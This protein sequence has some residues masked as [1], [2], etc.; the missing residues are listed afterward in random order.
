MKTKIYN[1]EIYYFD[2]DGIKKIISTDDEIKISK[3]WSQNDVRNTLDAF[4]PIKDENAKN[5]KVYNKLCVDLIDNSGQENTQTIFQGIITECDDNIKAVD[6]LEC[7]KIAKSKVDIPTSVFNGNRANVVINLLENYSGFKK[8]GG[9]SIINNTTNAGNTSVPSELE[10]ERD[11]FE[12]I[13]KMSNEGNF[14][15][16]P[17][18]SGNETNIV[19]SD[20]STTDNN[21]FDIRQVMTNEGVTNA[22]EYTT[23]YNYV[24]AY[25]LD[26]SNPDVPPVKLYEQSVQVI[27]GDYAVSR[28]GYVPYFY[29][30]E[31]FTNTT[32]THQTAQNLLDNFNN[33]SLQ[34]SFKMPLTADISEYSTFTYDAYSTNKSELTFNFA[35]GTID[36]KALFG[37]LND[38]NIG[39]N[40]ND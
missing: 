28:M 25:K 17:E 19:L 34:L 3:K 10:N 33:K 30:S 23:P 4:I 35:D 14:C 36:V 27:L 26:N 15:I 9:Y 16:Y 29:E 40:S 37:E 6:I 1:L 20:I 21:T 5:I 38:E 2:D 32:Q 24:S 11:V 18:F 7:L 22:H 13:I 39:E 8:D 12:N 31:F